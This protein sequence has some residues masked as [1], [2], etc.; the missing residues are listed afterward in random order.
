MGYCVF[1]TK[2][3]IMLHTKCPR[4]Q[5]TFHPVDHLLWRPLRYR[6]HCFFNT[7]KGTQMCQSLATRFYNVKWKKKFLPSHSSQPVG[8]VRPFAFTHY[9][10][11]WPR[12]RRLDCNPPQ[13]LTARYR[14][15]AAFKCCWEYWKVIH[16]GRKIT[17]KHLLISSLCK[18]RMDHM[19]IADNDKRETFHSLCPFHFIHIFIWLN[20]YG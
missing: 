9:K 15:N 13:R 6:L 17:T 8:A 16:F 10:T 19:I 18:A 1:Q 2:H 5:V 7:I 4:I 11:L 12:E 20:M 3:V 14:I